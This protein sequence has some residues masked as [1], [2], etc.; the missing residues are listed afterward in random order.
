MRFSNADT[1]TRIDGFVITD[2]YADYNWATGGGIR[3]DGSSSVLGSHPRIFN[4][5]FINN[6][7]GDGDAIANL[8]YSGS[9]SPKIYNCEFLNHTTNGSVV[10]NYSAGTPEIVN[11]RFSGNTNCKGVYTDGNI[12]VQIKNC[13]FTGSNASCIL[14]ASAKPKI[15]N[16]TFAGNQNLA[17]EGTW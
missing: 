8:G 14:S 13:L 4:C 2:S 10:Y 17:I 6:V 15:T 9:A 5:K 1:T 3:N 7:A 16:C 12:T 11:C